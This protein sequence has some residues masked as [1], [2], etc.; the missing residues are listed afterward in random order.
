M[1]ALP[2]RPVGAA[3]LL[4]RADLLL[5]ESI[6]ADQQAAIAAQNAAAAR[7]AFKIGALDALAAANLQTAAGDREREAITLR[8]QYLTAEISLATM[9]GLGLPPMETADLKAMP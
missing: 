2:S 7:H 1:P 9:L 6:V 8:T 4:Q 3:A 5:Q